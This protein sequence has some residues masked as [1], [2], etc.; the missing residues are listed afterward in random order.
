MSFSLVTRSFGC[1]SGR[2]GL[3]QTHWR[4]PRPARPAHFYNSSSQRPRLIFAFSASI[5][6]SRQLARADGQSAA[7]VHHFQIW[8]NPRLMIILYRMRRGAKSWTSPLRTCPI[9]SHGSTRMQSYQTLTHK[10]EIPSLCLPRLL[11]GVQQQVPAHVCGGAQ[12]I[13]AGRSEVHRR[14]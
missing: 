10:L 3:D 2:N 6:A 1:R 14:I 5:P 13:T 9:Y 4:P 8:R 7:L 12:V 11:G